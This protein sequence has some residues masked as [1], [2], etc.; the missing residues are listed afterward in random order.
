[1]NY[2]PNFSDYTT[3]NITDQTNW[4]APTAI[5]ASATLGDNAGYGNMVSDSMDTLYSIMGQQPVGIF[6]DRR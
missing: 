5:Y 1:M 4:Y 2:V 6:I 3:A